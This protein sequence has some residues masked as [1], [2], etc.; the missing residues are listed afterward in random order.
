[1]Q[2]SF[3]PEFL[4]TPD[5]QRVNE[6]I[7]NCVHCGFCNATCPTYQLTGDELDGPRGRIYLIKD[8]YEE[9]ATSNISLKHLDR[10][11][12]CLACETTC[13]SGVEFGGL[14]DIGRKHIEKAIER[15]T[16]NKLKRGLIISIFSNPRLVAPIFALAQIFRPLLPSNLAKK[17][18]VRPKPLKS[19]PSRSAKR[20]MLTIKGCVQSSAAP[21]INAAASEVLQH[22]NIQLDEA[23]TNCC[24]AL[25]FHLTDLEKAKQT[26]CSNIDSWYQKLCENHEYLLITSSG[27]S[28]FIKQYSTIM[29]ADSTYTEKANFISERCRD[30]SEITSEIK[31][32]TCNLKN[33]TVAFHSPCTLQHGQKILGNIE[34]K[35]KEAGYELV[36][37]RDSHLCCGSAGSYSLLETELSNKL[38]QNKITNLEEN[39]PDIIATANIGCLMHLSSGTKKPVKHWI[40]LL[41]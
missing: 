38:L 35:L 31:A 15:P 29:Q 33:K 24:G 3:T 30:L 11:L 28:S 17:I 6:I 1:M 20:K 4:Q 18:P 23:Q 34:N 19:T 14:V 32:N 16:F 26:V 10:C 41:V 40:E 7:R 22:S 39:Q 27:C 25:A 21:Q 2:T 12:T 13:P 37:I 36:A 5:G 8:F 9:K